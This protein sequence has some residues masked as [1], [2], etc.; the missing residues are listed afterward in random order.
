VI[1]LFGSP[2]TPL[3]AVYGPLT[4]AEFAITALAHT[5]TFDAPTTT[6]AFITATGIEQNDEN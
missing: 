5:L 6:S 3:G 4:F 2:T 1:Q